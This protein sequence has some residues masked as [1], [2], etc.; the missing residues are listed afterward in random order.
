M[1]R[2]VEKDRSFCEIKPPQTQKWLLKGV[3]GILWIH[4]AK[5]HHYDLPAAAAITG[6]WTDFDEHCTVGVTL[7]G[8]TWQRYSHQDDIS[9]PID[10]F[11]ECSLHL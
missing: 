1:A 11:I 2:D 8:S 3:F 5:Y 7:A 6:M 4:F 9:D 10:C